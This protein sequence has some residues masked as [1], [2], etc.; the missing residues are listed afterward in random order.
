MKY[1]RLSDCSDYSS[2]R[3]SNITFENYISTENMLPNKG[4]V[5]VASSLP[6]VKSTSAYKKDDILLSNI[7]PYFCKIWLADKEG[8][9]S[10]D[11]LVVRAKKGFDSK[12]LYYVLSD[13]NFFNWDT[14]TSK[15]TKMPRG[16]PKAIMKYFVPNVD[17]PTQQKI[18]G[19]LSKYDE[20]IENNNKRIKLLEQMAQNLY[21]EWFVRFRFPGWQNAE[22]ENGI[23]KGWKVEKL[24]DFCFI[25]DGTHDTPKQVEEGVPLVTGKAV[26]DRAI[27]F[28]VPYN[29][30]FE[31]HEKIKR[32]S[33]LETGDILF[34]NIGTVGNCCLVDYDREFSV[35]NMIIL[36]PQSEVKSQYLFQLLINDTMQNLFKNQT[37]GSSQQFIGLDFMRKFKILIPSEEV[38]KLFAKFE[39]K[40]T[41]LIVKLRQQTQNLSRQRDLLLPRLMSGKLQVFRK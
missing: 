2:E 13:K 34:S 10:N 36:K 22:F 35:K 38:L 7:R 39:I 6:D 9:C 26:I 15:G 11:V 23:P 14:V 19:I 25:T 41:K 29:I 1:L 18:A 12:F 24:E 37:N 31:D 33:G 16:T 32:R 40:C 4:G 27:D 3:T 5:T 20:A 17:L 28:S 30:S 8:S 21:K